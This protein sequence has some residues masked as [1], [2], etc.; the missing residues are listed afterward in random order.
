[1]PY[2]DI[3]G[4]PLLRNKSVFG[5]VIH[6][7]SQWLIHPFKRRLARWYL[8]ILQEFT[9]IKVIGV[10][11]SAGKSTTVQMIASILKRSAKTSATPPSIDPVYNVPNTILKTPYGTK[12]LILEF[13]VE[14]PGEMD[15]YLWLAKPDIGVITNIFPTHT[16]FL[17][18]VE[19]VFKEKSK[20]VES[21]TKDGFAV[22][23]EKDQRLKKLAQRSK[24]KI[25]WFAAKGNPLEQNAQ[26]AKAVCKCLNISSAKITQGIKNYKGL[27]HRLKI[28]HHQSGAVILDD[29]YNS[30]PQAVLATINVFNKLAGKNQ[31]IA[32]LGDMLELGAYEEEGHRLVGKKAAES[33]FNCVI[34]VG[35]AVKLLIDEVNKSSPKTKTIL[36][37]TV[38]NVSKEIRQFLRPGTSILIKGSRSI[39]L[40]KLV[41]DIMIDSRL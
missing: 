1:M 4:L 5:R 17:G 33:N 15:F 26:A 3:F 11:G 22:L 19:G 29:S 25:V 2:H 12:F 37:P 8:K 7:I 41:D 23:N 36:F 18:S 10:T 28:I 35:R 16:E 30:N 9:D 32:I 14:Y 6:L 21:L 34:G 39:G 20:L 31:K 40:D 24:A 38:N 13:S 27:E